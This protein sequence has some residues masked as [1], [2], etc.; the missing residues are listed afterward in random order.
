MTAG[1]V[2]ALYKELSTAATNF[3]GADN[4]DSELSG[5]QRQAFA[6][7]VVT[8][9]NKVLNKLGLTVT[10]CGREAPVDDFLRESGRGLSSLYDLLAD[11]Y[12]KD[13]LVRVMA[14]RL[15]G[16]RK[17]KMPLATEEYW[18]SKKLVRSLI[19]DSEVRDTSHTRGP[20]KHFNLT[21]I[22]VKANII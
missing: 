8:R 21:S 2:V 19:S 14:F 12:S 11:Q 5:K 10:T 4:W 1:F 9:V 18:K 22:G 6:A 17:V 15:L 7:A 16:H 3:Y 20:L 13:L